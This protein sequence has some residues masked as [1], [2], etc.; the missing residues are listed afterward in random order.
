M[1]VMSFLVKASTIGINNAKNLMLCNFGI[2]LA[3][4]FLVPI[5]VIMNL[6]YT[7]SCHYSAAE[8]SWQEHQPVLSPNGN[9]TWTPDLTNDTSITE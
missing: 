9:L 2:K 1:Y 4:K 7:L 5:N 8:D 3:N 6:R